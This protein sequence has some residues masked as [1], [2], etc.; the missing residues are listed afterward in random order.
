MPQ[1][2]PGFQR[3]SKPPAPPPGFSKQA[4]PKRGIADDFGRGVRNSAVDLYRGAAGLVNMPLDA[5]ATAYNT[6][7]RALYPEGY[8]VTVNGQKVRRSGMIPTAS[9]QTERALNQFGLTPQYGNNLE[10]AAGALS[11]GVGGSLPTLGLGGALSSLPGVTGSVGS[12][13][14][15]QPISQMVGAGTGAAS[16]EIARQQ[17]A[18]PGWQL[19]AGLAGGLAGGMLSPKTPTSSADLYSDFLAAQ[20]RA[21][22]EESLRASAGA[23]AGATAS[24]GVA[25]ASSLIQATPTVAARGGG[26]NFGS[27]GD[28]VTGLNEPMGRVAQSGREMGFRL[29]P[30]QITG[31]KA[32]Q[33]LEAKLESQ[34]MTSGPFN[35]IRSNNQTVLNRAVGANLGVSSRTLDEATLAGALDR[36]QNT[37]KD[38]ADDNVRQIDPRGYLQFV[39]ELQ[40]ETHG[41]VKGV[42]SH[43]LIEDLTQHAVSGGA[44]GRQLQSLTSKLGAAANKQM[45]TPSGD[46]DLGLALFRAKE[47][48]DDLL[49]QG[50]D[51][52]RLNNFMDARK[53][54]RALTLLTQRSGVVNPSS[55]NVRGGSLATVLQQKDRRGFT[56]GQNRTPMYEAARFAQAFGPIIGDSGTATRST[57]P[58]ATDWLISLPLNV[59]SKAYTSSPSVSAFANA[60]ALA[61]SLKGQAAPQAVGPALPAASLAAILA[62]QEA[63]RRNRERR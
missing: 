60:Q 1:P 36:I 20:N 53:Q 41:L 4:G 59:A 24:P 5:L 38:V 26:Y 3:V 23:T 50:L 33:Q 40:D 46:R 42:L 48:V 61:R 54:Y 30:G 11:R 21:A 34:P 49:T 32:L 12:Q 45:T 25:Q 13:L 39:S 9:Q 15:A 2:P 52:T 22:R 18:G 55:G 43:D 35:A 14:A 27:V 37:F 19:A 56:F 28:D 58:S 17:G 16:S 57:L 7:T 47:Y 8:E 6:V 31:S 44:T 10:S 63:A 29:T 62:D 51:E